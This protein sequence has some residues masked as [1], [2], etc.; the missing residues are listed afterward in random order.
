MKKIKKGLKTAEL[1]QQKSIFICTLIGL[2]EE[3]K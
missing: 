2:R 1:K 3:I